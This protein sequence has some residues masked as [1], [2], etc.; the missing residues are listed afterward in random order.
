[1]P[2]S[3]VFTLLAL[4][5]S[6]SMVVVLAPLASSMKLVDIPDEELKGHGRVVPIVGGLAVF[7]TF[8][9][10]MAG[11]GVFDFAF[12]WAALGVFLVGLID[13]LMGL[14]PV[15]RLLASAA[16][17]IG[18]V[19]LGGFDVQIGIAISLIVLIVVGVNA[20]N[21]LDGA[22]GVAGSAAVISALG[23]AIVSANRGIDPDPALILAGAIGGF[24]VFNW[25][26]ARIFLGDGGAYTIGFTL[27]Y[28]MVVATPS[29]E[30]VTG[31]WYWQ[32][33]V[34]AG[35]FG[36]FVIDLVVTF[37]RRFFARVP[38]FGGDRSHVY[39]QLAS[40][41]WS[42]DAVAATVAMSQL[43]VVAAV[44]YADSA[45]EP[46][47]AGLATAGL[48]ALTVILL[49]AAGFVTGGGRHESTQLDLT[50]PA[51]E[52]P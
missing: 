33:L 22:D 52:A 41:G 26:K 13:D 38:L 16:G 4:I 14:S 37:L 50:T 21:L 48:L 23:L 29:P 10:V 7:A 39:D 12:F 34:A 1:M 31:E 11:A 15:I 42:A 9:A 2:E 47:I 28:L 19:F 27:A 43:V 36:V 30:G 25:P 8:M 6:G 45:Y 35:L 20:V 3:S 17:G 51:V 24:L 32:L 18:L 49:W 5:I 46:M 44:V 40:R